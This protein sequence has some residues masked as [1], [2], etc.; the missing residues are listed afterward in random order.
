MRKPAG[1]FSIGNHTGIAL[2]IGSK[3]FAVTEDW[4]DA[5][6]IKRMDYGVVRWLLEDHGPAFKAEYGGAEGKGKLSGSEHG[7]RFLCDQF[8]VGANDNEAVEAITNDDGP[9]GEWWQRAAII[10]RSARSRMPRL[11]SKKRNR[12]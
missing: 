11:E 9:A 4:I 12:N 3:F 8:T 5:E 6:P 7:F 10:N 1:E 2:Y